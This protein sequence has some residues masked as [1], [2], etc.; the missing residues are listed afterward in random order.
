MN[1]QV[2]FASVRSVPVSDKL[3]YQLS[4]MSLH[5]QKLPVAVTSLGGE[6]MPVIKIPPTAQN[7]YGNTVSVIRIGGAAF[8]GNEHITDILLPSTVSYISDGA[9]AGCCNLR[10]IT[11]PKNVRRIPQGTFVGCGSLEHIFYE[12]SRAEWEQMHIIYTRFEAEFGDLIP[13]TPVHRMTE[14]RMI[15]IPGNDALFT[16]TIHFHCDLSLIAYPSS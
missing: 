8:R 13:G 6:T 9:F 5:P 14:E 16:A 10:N 2:Y 1:H 15:H 11:I 4:A 7:K 12:G 3:Q